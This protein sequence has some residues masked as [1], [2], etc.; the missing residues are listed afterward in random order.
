MSGFLSKPYRDGNNDFL[1]VINTRE[2][3]T[4]V[5]SLDSKVE[6]VNVSTAT[7]YGWAVRVNISK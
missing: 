1:I 3:K 2:P 6:S 4:E 5:K 7:S